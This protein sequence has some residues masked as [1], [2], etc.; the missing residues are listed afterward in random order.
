MVT[1]IYISQLLHQLDELEFSALATF[2]QNLT[3]VFSLHHE[4][5][6]P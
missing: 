3:L 2:S 6:L 4:V 5:R 1:R